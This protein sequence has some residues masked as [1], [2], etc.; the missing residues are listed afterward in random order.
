MAE[1]PTEFTTAQA[2]FFETPLY[3]KLAIEKIAD[4]K[5]FL[6]HELTMDGFCPYCRRYSTFYRSVGTTRSNY[7]DEYYSKLEEFT[8]NVVK[9]ARDKE[10]HVISFYSLLSN[11]TVQ[12][13]GQFPSFADI[14]IDESKTYSKFLDKEDMAEFHKAIGLAAH[15]VGIGSYVYLRRVFEG[16]ID[17]RFWDDQEAQG[18]SNEEF[19]KLRMAERIEFLKDYLPPFLVENAKIYSILSLGVH[20]LDEDDCLAFFPVLRQSTVWILDQDKKKKEELAEQEALRKAIAGFQ[21]KT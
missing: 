12:K 9:C 5:Q 13:V 7:T 18:W 1:K 6:W 20:E 8:Y 14:A 15:G 2:Y 21:P 19:Y 3:E 16:L 17:K 4:I 10:D 11:K